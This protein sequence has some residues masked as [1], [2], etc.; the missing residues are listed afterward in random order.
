VR[1]VVQMIVGHGQSEAFRRGYES[2]VASLLTVGYVHVWGKPVR[3]TLD[4]P[5][6]EPFDGWRDAVFDVANRD[7]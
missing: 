4:W 1:D 2:S 5:E 6:G 7:R 3:V